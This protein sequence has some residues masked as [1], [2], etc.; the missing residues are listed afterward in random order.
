MD[1]SVIRNGIIKKLDTKTKYLYS[2]YCYDV[3]KKYNILFIVTDSGLYFWEDT[4]NNTVVRIKKYESI[5]EVKYSNNIV[6]LKFTDETFLLK[7]ISKEDG[8]SIIFYRFIND[9][10]EDCLNNIAKKAKKKKSTMVPL[11][12]VKKKEPA[13]QNREESRQEDVESDDDIDRKRLDSLAMFSTATTPIAKNVNIHSPVGSHE[14]KTDGFDND[15]Y[16]DKR[17]SNRKF[18]ANTDDEKN[19]P[20]VVKIA[21]I[22]ICGLAVVGLIVFLL[23]TFVF[24][25]KKEP[26]QKNPNDDTGQTTH[27]GYTQTRKEAEI[28]VEDLNN[29]NEVLKKDK[30]LYELIQGTYDNYK[31]NPEKFDYDA[32]K[33][34]IDAKFEELSQITIA[35]V[36]LESKI[37]GNVEGNYIY[38]ELKKNENTLNDI[39]TSMYLNFEKQFS[40]NGRVVELETLL[41]N[42]MSSNQNITSLINDELTIFEAELENYDTGSIEDEGSDVIVE[43]NNSLV[44]GVEEK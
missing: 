43:D 30:T 34:E 15:A 11:P 12:N 40:D 13:K 5:K 33:A 38:E 8:E 2:F 32:A 31:A 14:K 3:G 10:Y 23:M 29:L 28:K 27:N 24:G 7:Q 25:G 19:G 37:S 17:L 26:A 35:K 6:S 36:S 44:G 4:G 16:N 1:K 20:P 18:E 42:M 9:F 22:A 39:K 41:L 21:I